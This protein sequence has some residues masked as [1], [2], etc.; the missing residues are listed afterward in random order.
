MVLSMICRVLVPYAAA[1]WLGQILC[2]IAVFVLACRCLSMAGAVSWSWPLAA[3]SIEPAVVPQKLCILAGI[4]AG[5]GQVVFPLLQLRL[6]YSVGIPAR[7]WLLHG[8]VPVVQWLDDSVA[9]GSD[10]RIIVAPV[11]SVVE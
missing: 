11:V 10:Y 1:S 3:G 9:C 6:L 8:S 2:S 7:R 4:P 5:P